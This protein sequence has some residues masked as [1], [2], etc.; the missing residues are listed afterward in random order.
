MQALLSQN[1]LLEQTAWAYPQ[2]YP[3]PDSQI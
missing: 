1:A 2:G 3:H